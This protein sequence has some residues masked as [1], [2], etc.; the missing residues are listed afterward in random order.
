MGGGACHRGR[1]HRLG[2]AQPVPVKADGI[3]SPGA[4]QFSAGLVLCSS[5]RVG[6]WE[7][8]EPFTNDSRAGKEVIAGLLVLHRKERKVSSASCLPPP[9]L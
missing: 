2:T 8:T 6:A 1:L 4:V 9:T 3:G 7:R 5:A